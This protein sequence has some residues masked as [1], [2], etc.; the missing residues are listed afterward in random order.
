MPRQISDAYLHT[1]E[2]LTS[3]TGAP[4]RAAYDFLFPPLDD[5]FSDD[6]ASSNEMGWRASSARRAVYQRS[7]SNSGSSASNFNADET[8]DRLDVWDSLNDSPWSFV[9]SRYAFA[10]VIVAIVNNRVQHICRPRRGATCCLSQLQRIALRLPSLILLAR[11]VLIL[12]IVVADA[13]LVESNLI[14]LLLRSCTTASWRNAW[15]ANTPMSGWAQ[16]RFGASSRDELLRARDASALWAAF[17]ST[18][19]AVVSDSMV[20]N[21]DADRDEP[22]AFNLVGFAFLLHFHSFSPEAPANEHVYLCVLLQ[23]LQILT[24]ALSRCRRPVYASRLVISSFFGIGSLLHYALAANSGR[25]PFLEALSRTPEIALVMIVL[26]TVTLHALTMLLLEGSIKLDRLVFSRSNLPCRDEDW[27][28]ALF[29]LGT[30]C[31]ESTRLTGLER[32]VEPLVAWDAPYIELSAS[33]RIQLVDPLLVRS[34]ASH[35]TS[36]TTSSLHRVSSGG[37]SR[38]VKQ[39]RIEPTGQNR[40]SSTLGHAGLPR[41]R[42]LIQFLVVTLLVLGNLA[43]MIFRK[44]LRIT[45]LPDPSVPR[46]VYRT[47]GL[48]RDRKSVV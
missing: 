42:A 45:G 26:L 17:T 18:C 25:Y 16:D 48:A 34:S 30:A 38:E 47:L 15:L 24:I 22:P 31:M 2:W 37:L 8:V 9:I 40:S 21:L 3:T 10:L 5:L 46:W 4:L 23:M 6:A 14:N 33:G 36:E 44:I 12:T 39:V 35:L 19:V 7:A 32:E 43:M 20:R 27:S 28:L 1:K 13:F 41:V 11:S 29:K